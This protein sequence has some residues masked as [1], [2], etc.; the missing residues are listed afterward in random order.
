M[1]MSLLTVSMRDVVISRSIGCSNE[2]YNGHFLVIQR[3]ESG[4]G[5]G[6]AAHYDKETDMKT[7]DETLREILVGYA[8]FACALA[9]AAPMVLVTYLACVR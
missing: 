7:G 4:A 8:A 9:S 5:K 2:I 3:F 6:N 1:L